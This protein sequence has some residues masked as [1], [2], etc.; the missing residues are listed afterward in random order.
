[1]CYHCYDGGCAYCTGFLP[2]SQTESSVEVPKR[3]LKEIKRL[4]NK[5]D[6]EGMQLTKQ[7]KEI[8]Q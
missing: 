5:P 8:T 6:H 4:K 7:S 3:S 2:K 1:M